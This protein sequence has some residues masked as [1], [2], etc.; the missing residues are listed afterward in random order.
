MTWI[1]KQAGLKAPDPIAQKR[2]DLDERRLKFDES[3]AGLRVP[4][5]IAQGRLKLE[6]DKF[7]FDKSQKSAK[8]ATEV[9]AFKKLAPDQQITIKKLASDNAQRESVANQM[10]EEF[11][12]FKNAKETD[13][14]MSL[15]SKIEAIKMLDLYLG[16]PSVLFDRDDTSILRRTL[17]GKAGEFRP[18]EYGIEYRVLG[19]YVA[20]SP[21]LIRL[22]FDLVEH[23][24][25]LIGEGEAEKCLKLLP[26]P[27][28]I[29]AINTVNKKMAESWV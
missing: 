8:T 5:P 1:P 7:E 19:P 23:T 13:P 20:N 6:Q 10:R 18:T 12:N 16:L 22:A 25:H 28:V 26:Q 4:D 27:K 24:M 3:K 17:Y 29:E 21:R 15:K 14:L 9:E 11:K 2:L